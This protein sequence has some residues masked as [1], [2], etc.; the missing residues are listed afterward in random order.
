VLVYTF[1]ILQNRFFFIPKYFP[2]AY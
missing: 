2:S 1:F